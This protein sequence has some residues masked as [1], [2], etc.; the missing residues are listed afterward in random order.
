[1]FF[2]TNVPGAQITPDNFGPACIQSPLGEISS[3]IMTAS[4][5]HFRYFKNCFR[6]TNTTIPFIFVRA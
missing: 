5:S 3:L 2:F 6:S 1:M 4:Q